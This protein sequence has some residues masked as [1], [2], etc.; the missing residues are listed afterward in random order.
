[1]S[2]NLAP[3]PGLN[4]L[5]VGWLAGGQRPACQPGGGPG[6]PRSGPGPAGAPPTCR[7]SFSFFQALPFSLCVF[8]FLSPLFS[9]FPLF[10]PRPP[11]VECGTRYPGLRSGATFYPPPPPV[12][13]GT[14]YP[15]LRSVFFWCPFCI[16]PFCLLLSSSPLFLFSSFYPPPP[17]CGMWN[18][19]PRVEVGGYFLPPAPPCG[20]WN[21]VSRIEVGFFLVPF[22]YFPFLSPP[23]LLSYFPFFSF[24]PPP[25]PCGMWN[26]LPRIEV[27]GYFFPPAP[28]CGMWNA[29][30]R[31]EVDFFLVPSAQLFLGDNF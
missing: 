12:G 24:Y 31:I 6:E 4:F 9:F 10:T 25:P 14:R 21:S 19:V 30:S 18:A 1:M 27:G 28:P 29:V 20:M 5:A 23:L 11:P 26:A 3:P 22:L 17:P 16:F 15:G 7:L 8:P 13:C 2:R